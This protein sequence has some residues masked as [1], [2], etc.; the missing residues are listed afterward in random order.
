MI[1]SEI[2]CLQ[3]GQIRPMLLNSLQKILATSTSQAI[4]ACRCAFAA[5]RQ[6]LHSRKICFSFHFISVIG[7]AGFVCTS[8]FK[9]GS[10]FV[11]VSLALSR[12]SLCIQRMQVLNEAIKRSHGLSLVHAS[13]EGEKVLEN[14]AYVRTKSWGVI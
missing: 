13:A 6:S 5:F 12:N 3:K 14:P 10:F 7:V 11:Y 2:L 8:C 4:S 1:K 9:D